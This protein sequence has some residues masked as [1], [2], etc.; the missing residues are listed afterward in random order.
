MVPPGEAE[1]YRAAGAIPVLHDADGAPLKRNFVHVDDL[2]A[3][4][5]AALTHPRASRQRFNICMDEPV[6]YRAVA[7]YLARTRGLPSVDISSGFHS[8][9]LDNAK[10]K[11]LLDWRPAYDMARLIEA[12][13]SYQ[14]ASDDP[15]RIWYPG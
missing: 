14:R 1:A 10:A 7:D 11:F 13:W 8:N 5:V 3:A 12:A 4:M 15:R 6:D 9:W 2:V